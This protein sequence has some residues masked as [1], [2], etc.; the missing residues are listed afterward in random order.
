MFDAEGAGL[1]FVAYEANDVR[2]FGRNPYLRRDQMAKIVARSLSIYQRKHSGDAPRRV[3]MHKST[4]F[5]NEE[6]DGV[7]DAFPGAADVELVHVQ[8]SCGGGVC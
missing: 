5:R 8:Q 3:V 7:F 1:E 6:V 4:E 2:L